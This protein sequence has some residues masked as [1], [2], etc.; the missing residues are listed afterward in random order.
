[1]YMLYHPY[2]TPVPEHSVQIAE[3]KCSVCHEL[4]EY[5]HSK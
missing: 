3:G 1:M 5:M 2:V 4:L